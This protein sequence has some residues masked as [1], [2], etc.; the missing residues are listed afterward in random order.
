MARGLEVVLCLVVFLFVLHAKTAVY[1]GGTGPRVTPSTANKLWLNGEKLELEPS[2]QLVSVELWCA[3]LFLHWF[4]IRRELSL[5]VPV[6]T[7]APAH[8]SLQDLHRSL[9]PPPPR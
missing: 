9:R 3:I 5:P 4:S 7:S 2:I 6:R 1:K 8:E